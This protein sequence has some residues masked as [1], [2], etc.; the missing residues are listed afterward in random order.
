MDYDI[1]Q[2]FRSKRTSTA[3]RDNRG[4]SN[5]DIPNHTESALIIVTRTETSTPESGGTDPGVQPRIRICSWLHSNLTL[6]TNRN[7]PSP[8]VARGAVNMFMY[9]QITAQK[10]T[11]A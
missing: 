1:V 9:A 7:P 6:S 2:L 5:D 3:K 4:Q 8:V 10:A 11:L